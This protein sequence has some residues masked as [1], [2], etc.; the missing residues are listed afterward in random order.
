[1]EKLRDLLARRVREL[2]EKNPAMDT[3]VKLAKR[4]GISQSTVQRVLARENAA[5]LDVVEDLGKAF[6]FRPPSLILAD[7]EHIELAR[8]WSRMSDAERTQ[9]LESARQMLQQPQAIGERK[10]TQNTRRI[11]PALP[12]PDDVVMMSFEEHAQLAPGHFRQH[13]AVSQVRSLLMSQA[14]SAQKLCA[15]IVMTVDDKGQTDINSVGLEPSH[16]V[17]LMQQLGDLQQRLL[18]LVTGRARHNSR[19]KV[20]P[21]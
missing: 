15:V 20:S 10:L 5:T 14:L 6:G 2:M 9:L 4:A 7:N 13:E 17:P 8:A 21:E 11:P 16:A 12:A 3:Q 1:M 18:T 19:R